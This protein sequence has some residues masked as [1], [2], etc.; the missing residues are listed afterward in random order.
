MS[1]DD[2]VK[3]AMNDDVTVADLLFRLRKAGYERRRP[4]PPRQASPPLKLYW[5]VRQRR[6]KP[7]KKKTDSTRA[8]PTTPLSWS[9]ATSVSGGCA[10][11]GFEESSK[12]V[13]P[14]GGA[15]SKVSVKGEPTTSK[16]P[17]KK[18]TLAELK[19][20]ETLLL[21][22]RKKLRS[23]IATMRLNIEKQK[24][25]NENL[26]RLKIDLVSPQKVKTETSYQAEQVDADAV[27]KPRSIS[28]PTDVDQGNELVAHQQP[29][30]EVEELESEKETGFSLPDLNLPADTDF[31]SSGVVLYGIS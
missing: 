2:W 4:P 1:D 20:E 15:R 29:P 24:A 21:R 10:I 8:S 28:P 23:E 5:S 30:Q 9:G 22:E 12:P 14:T 26:N 3:L 25:T 17:R 31:S 6:S 7:L 11:D 27:S 19:E 16:R 13:K 18:K